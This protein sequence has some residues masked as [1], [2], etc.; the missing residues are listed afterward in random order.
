MSI[1]LTP[2]CLK[3]SRELKEK[4]KEGRGGDGRGGEVRNI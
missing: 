4:N 3:N 2:E 1:D